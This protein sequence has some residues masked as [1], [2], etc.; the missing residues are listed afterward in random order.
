MANYA[1]LRGP[2][3]T[4][5]VYVKVEGSFDHAAFLDGIRARRTVATNAPL[6][7]FSVNG[8]EIGDEIELPAGTHRVRIQGTMRSPV[9]IDHLQIVANGEVVEELPLAGDGRAADI[10]LELDIDRSTWLTLRAWTE[11]AQHPILD[12][13]PFGTTSPVWVTVGG[14]PIRSPED[15]AYFEAWVGRLEEVARASAAYNDEAERA[16]VLDTLTR[17][18]AIFRERAADR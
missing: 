12:Y 3:G 11:A 14:E 1:S 17:A 13:Y 15:A 9:P 6:L 2:L 18:R 7:T 4:N 10:D 16:A 8:A 5:R